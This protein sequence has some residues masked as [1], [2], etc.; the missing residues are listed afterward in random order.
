MRNNRPV[1]LREFLPPDPGL[2]S[3]RQARA[4]RRRRTGPLIA[5]VVVVGA[6]ATGSVAALITS[7]PGSPDASGVA[8]YPSST[9]SSPA[10]RGGAPLAAVEA[11]PAA[12]PSAP[13]SVSAAADPPA[14]MTMPVAAPYRGPDWPALTYTLKAVTGDMAPAPFPR[15]VPGYVLKDSFT[16]QVSVSDARRFISFGD[17]PVK[18]VSYAQCRQQ[19]FYIRWQST[20][21][22]AVV[23]ATFVDSQVRTVQN[24]PVSGTAGWQSS[25]GCVQPA[26]RIRP[27]AGSGPDHTQVVAQLQVWVRR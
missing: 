3:R 12:D 9:A 1:A 27:A 4:R 22:K 13:A 14:S 15:A 23:E 8:A 10:S 21:P 5:G 2:T 16:T 11:P 26:V 17:L 20:D 6:A 19:R 18:N 7:S 24:H 25:F